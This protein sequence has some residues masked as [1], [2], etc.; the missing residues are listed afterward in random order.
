MPQQPT[1]TTS[2]LIRIKLAGTQIDQATVDAL[3][4]V[5]IDQHAHLP[6]MFRI[7]FHD[8]GFALIDKGP[9]D[10]TKE[11]EII[12]LD[13][14]HKAH[15]LIKGEIT[16]IEPEFAEGMLTYLV[17]HGYDKSHRLFRETKSKSYLNKKDSDLAREIAQNVGLSAQVETTSTV[18]E[19]IFQH[20]QSDMAF[21]KQRA[22]RIGFE[23]F[24]EEGKLYF[25]KPVQSSSGVKLKWGEDLI[26]FMPRMTLAE[27]VDE[28]MVRGWDVQAQQAIVGRAA[29]GRL[30]PQNGE[31][32]DGKAWAG[33]FGTGKRIIVDQ[34]VV[35]QAE[36]NKLA[37]ARLDELSG[38]FVEAEGVA[39]RR[40]D[41]RAGKIIEL[42]NVGQRF[43]GKYLV[44]NATHRYSQDGFKTTFHVR[45]TRNGLLGEQFSDL[46]PSVKWP[47][48]VTAIVTNTE[49]ETQWGSVKV[50]FPWMSDDAESAWARVM[51][52]GA[53]KNAGLNLIPDV[54]D[55]VLVAFEL[56]DFNRPVV[57]GGVWN[58]K[59]EIPD[60]TSTAQRGK[61]PQI[62]TWR[63]RKG[64]IIA[65]HDETDEKVELI[66]AGGHTVTL[67]DKGK[68]IAVK[69]SQGH[70]VTLDDQGRS[71][72]V[73]SIGTLKIEA[74]Q[75][76][77]I[78][79]GAT[80]DIEGQM[81]NIKGQMV[82]L[83]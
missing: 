72:T 5:Y 64:H 31:S 2:S 9:F 61:R 7:R 34:P 4:D 38:A 43:S 13:D 39:F 62:R 28:V 18:Y 59:H 42:E 27:Q 15:T 24:V 54:G 58:G 65:M 3:E 79:A 51:G 33:A 23:C 40:P 71:I 75:A 44:T 76:V 56:G 26:S 69:S 52:L 66:T 30:Y 11:I 29:N 55:E 10:L 57:L 70:E 1:A 81:V 35:S 60:P 77:Q 32:K 17:V 37:E 74:A 36:A 49:D 22:W 82:K 67:D 48:I 80:L 73:K 21:L 63:S 50:K 16:A 68:K 41:I 78:K 46:D 14:A 45:G 83:N 8:T 20:N 47:G 19:H 12:G 25:Q 53:G 6:A